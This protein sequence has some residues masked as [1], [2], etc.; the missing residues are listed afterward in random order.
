MKNIFLHYSVLLFA[1]KLRNDLLCKL[2][3]HFWTYHACYSDY[4]IKKCSWCKVQHNWNSTHEDTR[5]YWSKA[6]KDSD[7]HPVNTKI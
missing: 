6:E 7:F 1:L 3:F 2:G 5:G 4:V